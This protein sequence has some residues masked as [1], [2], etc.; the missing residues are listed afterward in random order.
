MIAMSPIP[1][2][3][4]RRSLIALLLLAS[5]GAS[6]QVSD[7]P[8][9]WSHAVSILLRKVVVTPAENAIEAT[10]EFTAGRRISEADALLMRFGD[11]KCTRLPRL[12]DAAGLL[13][14]AAGLC[15]ADRLA[16]ARSARSWDIK[17]QSH[18]VTTAVLH[19]DLPPGAAPRAP[20]DLEIPFHYAISGEEDRSPAI[21]AGIATLRWGG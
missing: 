12:K 13:L 10:L 5:G 7:H 4:D 17:L 1:N 3:P 9:R 19:F 18:D 15:R 11:E 8:S 21:H 20:F 2:R 16:S 14:V 6:A